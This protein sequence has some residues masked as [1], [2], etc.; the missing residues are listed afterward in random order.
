MIL[1][2]PALAAP[3]LCAAGIA[4]ADCG[5][6]AYLPAVLAAQYPAADPS[7]DWV[8][9]SGPGGD[10]CITAWSLPGAA[11]TVAAIVAAAPAILRPR[12]LARLGEARRAALAARGAETWPG[13]DADEIALAIVA[14]EPSPEIVADYTGDRATILTTYQATAATAATLDADAAWTCAQTGVL[15]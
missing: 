9:G 10:Y 1:L 14:G 8:L 13:Y 4:A 7:S 15:P 6:P 5:Y 11:P 2:R 12:C 3:L